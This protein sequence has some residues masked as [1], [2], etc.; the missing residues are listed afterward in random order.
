MQAQN[1]LCGIVLAA[2][3]PAAALW[4]RLQ[5]CC[6]FVEATAG[7]GLGLCRRHAGW[8]VPTTAGL[9]LVVEATAGPGLCVCRWHA[10]WAVTMT[11]GG[12][13]ATAAAHVAGSARLHPTD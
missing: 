3:A 7:P 8:V 6:L 4:E 11:A 1:S 10:G 5:V 9:L 2:G 12:I 13:M